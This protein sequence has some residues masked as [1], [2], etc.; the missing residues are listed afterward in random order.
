MSGNTMKRALALLLLMMP[1]PWLPARAMDGLPVLQRVTLENQELWQLETEL[2]GRV[3]HNGAVQECMA[4]LLVELLQKAGMAPRVESLVQVLTTPS[5]SGSPQAAIKEML[6]PLDGEI[7][8][9][10]DSSVAIITSSGRSRTLRIFQDT[11]TG[12]VVHRL[13]R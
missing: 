8:V 5:A 10:Q 2:T 3:E 6:L 12:F 9:S 7:C 4:G 13:K 11:A 1:S